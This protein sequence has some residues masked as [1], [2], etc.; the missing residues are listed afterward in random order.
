VLIP[1]DTQH[2][3]ALARNL[4]CAGVTRD[5]RHTV[6]VGQ[7]KPPAMTARN[8]GVWRRWAKL[9]ER[10]L[11][12]PEC[13]V[14]SQPSEGAAGPTLLKTR[15]VRRCCAHVCPAPAWPYRRPKN[16]PHRP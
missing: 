10:L 16:R 12:M 14:A 1:L 8:A 9:Q 4:L 13:S 7:R 2:D 11:R 3:A 15:G 6:S 5:K